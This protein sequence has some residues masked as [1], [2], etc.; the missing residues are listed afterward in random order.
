MGNMFGENKR[1]A[2]PLKRAQRKESGGKKVRSHENENNNPIPIRASKTNGT[3]DDQERE[4]IRDHMRSEPTLGPQTSLASPLPPYT[5]FIGK[6][7]ST[8]KRPSH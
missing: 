8:R 7:S 6:Y 2:K 5:I 3:R 4:S 1:E